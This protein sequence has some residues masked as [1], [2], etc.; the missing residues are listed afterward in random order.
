MK[1]IQKLGILSVPLTFLSAG[2][3]MLYLLQVDNLDGS[4]FERIQH[5]SW[6]TGHLFL[7]FS[8]VL[9]MPAALSLRGSIEKK[10]PSI[11]ATI[12]VIIIAPTSIL[13]SGQ[14]AIDFVMPLLGQAGGEALQV[15]G[16]LYGS[17]LIETLFYGLPNLVFL[18]LML[19]SVAVVWN[20]TLLKVPATILMINWSA[21]ILGNLIDPLFQRMAILLLA[22]SFV[23]FVL[24]MVQ[25][26]KETVVA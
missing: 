22:G 18:A 20:G 15:H 9:M 24:M 12:M 21:V 6:I 7:L 11:L 16:L 23:P 17:A 3:G 25:S 10:A 26:K 14:Y 4:Y 1:L 5:Q 2:V 19:L 13:L 8:T